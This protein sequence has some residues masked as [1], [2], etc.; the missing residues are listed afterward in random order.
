[1]Y[2]KVVSI[3]FLAILYN[4]NIIKHLVYYKGNIHISWGQQVSYAKHMHALWLPWFDCYIL[5]VGQDRIVW[6]PTKQMFGVLL[7]LP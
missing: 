7:C 2:I 5:I 4:H 1:M 6:A 3:I